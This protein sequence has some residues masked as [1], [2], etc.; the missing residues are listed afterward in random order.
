ML[1]RTRSATPTQMARGVAALRFQC[2]SGFHWQKRILIEWRFLGPRIRR[3]CSDSS[4]NVQLFEFCAAAF[5]QELLQESDTE[6]QAS[7]EENI[8]E[9]M[10]SDS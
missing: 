7:G 9:S 3:L 8:E 10:S 5:M 1:H 2:S 6:S 4:S